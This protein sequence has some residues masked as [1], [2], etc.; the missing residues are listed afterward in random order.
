MGN[1]NIQFL[2]NDCSLKYLEVLLNM[3]GLQAVITVPIGIIRK[4]SLQLIREF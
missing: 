1:L 2:K 3:F 4:Q